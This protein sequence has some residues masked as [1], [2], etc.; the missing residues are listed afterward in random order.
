MDGGCSLQDRDVKGTGGK[1]WV[2]LVERGKRYVPD[3]GKE[4]GGV[5]GGFASCHSYSRRLNL[6][7]LYCFCKDEKPGR[8]GSRGTTMLQV[9]AVF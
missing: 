6:I 4:R 9:D 2:R 8:V 3:R 7:F 1:V 5:D